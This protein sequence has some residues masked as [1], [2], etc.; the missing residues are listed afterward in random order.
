MTP[1]PIRGPCCLW[2]DSDSPPAPSVCPG[3]GRAVAPHGPD[4]RVGELADL[5]RETGAV[6]VLCATPDGYAMS[7]CRPGAAVSIAQFPPAFPPDVGEDYADPIEA[8]LE[9]ATTWPR[10]D[11]ERA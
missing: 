2:C 4:R 8:L 7:F 9:I 6:I 11:G 3:C 1:L 10:P 5:M